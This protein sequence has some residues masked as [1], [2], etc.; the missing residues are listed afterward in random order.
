MT[1]LNDYETIYILKPDVTEDINLSLVSYYKVMLKEQGAINIS[2]QHR[3][4]RHL[5]YNIINYY[6]GIYIQMNY[7]GNGQLVNIIEKSMKLNDNIIRY[8]TIKKNRSLVNI[9]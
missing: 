8:L 5:S 2:V 3:G 6:D 1:F 4:R 9:Y 7:Q